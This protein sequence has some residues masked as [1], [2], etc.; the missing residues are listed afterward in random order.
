MLNLQPARVGMPD[1]G[2]KLHRE[3]FDAQQGRYRLE[4]AGVAERSYDIELLT[5][6]K[7]KS[8]EGGE[9]IGQTDTTT[10]IRATLG[11]AG[12]KGEL[13]DHTIVVELL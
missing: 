3:S 10:T 13:A 4:V 2:I 7:V 9:I 1:E 12:G 11:K 5:L 6:S 8:V